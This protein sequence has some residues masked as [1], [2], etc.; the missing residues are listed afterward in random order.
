MLRRW[1]LFSVAAVCAAATIGQSKNEL[2]FCLRSEPG[3]LNPLLVDDDAS[4][5]I[6][7][8]TGGVLIRLN[9]VTQEL[10]PG[11]ALSWKVAPDGKQ[12]RFRLRTGVR[13][14]D[15]TPFD[16]QDVAY[17]MNALMD[18]ELHSPTGDAFRT[19]TQPPRTKVLG[20]DDVAISFSEPVASLP[21][22][23]DQVA[24]LSS[25]SPDKEKSVLGPFRVAERV[26]GSHLV[27]VRNPNYWKR[28]AQ[29]HSLPYLDSLRIQIQPNRD[30]EAL[31]LTRGEID[32][33]AP[34]DPVL[35]EKLQKQ[36]GL[37]ARDAGPSFDS[38]FVWFNQTGSQALPDYKRE[39]FRSKAFRN[40][41]SLAINRQELAATVYR[42]HAQPSAGP[43]PAANRLWF[44]S[45]LKA[46]G[47]DPEAAKRLLAGAGFRYQGTTLVDGAGHAVTFSLITNSGSKT[48]E[49]LAALI[50]RDLAEI[51]INVTVATLDFPGLLAR[52]TRN[53][54][55]EACLLGLQNVDL[56]PNGQMNIWLSSSA[57]HQWN[58]SQKSPATQWE[59]DIDAAMTAQA[60]LPDEKRRK[61]Q[62]DRVQQI[63]F[64]QEPFIYLVHPNTLVAV[65]TRVKNLQPSTLRPQV[66]W[67]VD[68][69]AVQ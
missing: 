6:R 45:S 46:R 31:A 4:E 50:Q 34:L 62:F 1:F 69:L 63:I 3:T 29:G 20:P 57:N 32:L 48:R 39:W 22:L 30:L 18:P 36:D 9:R 42:G 67:N 12:I 66:L 60:R 35:F 23:F 61:A 49:R 40:A 65:S 27:L 2:R 16:A 14:S 13:F 47:H 38:E 25:R 58:P 10:E 43:F 59:A 52:I 26:S 19:G 8:L 56:D 51:G 5:T 41:V 7:Y 64:E 15:G 54:D 37:T 11:L 33:I 21:R 28:D 53:F 17:T 24:I 44:N 68:T 55:Y